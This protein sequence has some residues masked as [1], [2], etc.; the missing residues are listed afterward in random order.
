LN[1]P[2]KI[3]VYI[4]KYKYFWISLQLYLFLNIKNKYNWIF[5]QLKKYVIKIFCQKLIKLLACLY[6]IQYTPSLG[7]KWL[8]L[9]DY[10]EYA[11]TNANKK[12]FF[13]VLLN[14]KKKFEMEFFMLNIWVFKYSW[15][16]FENICFL[17]FESICICI[18]KTNTKK[19]KVFD[20]IWISNIFF[21]IRI[22]SICRYSSNSKVKAGWEDFTC[23]Q[24]LMLLAWKGVRKVANFPI[25]TFCHTFFLHYF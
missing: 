6:L 10:D 5:S 17:V 25:A 22:N 23:K 13:Q 8:E 15:L 16:T 11:F 2:L 18:G 20:A 14:L 7:L 3:F 4:H 1:Y 12:K 19:N 21:N 24:I 9:N